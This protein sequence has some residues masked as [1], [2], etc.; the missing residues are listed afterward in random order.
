MRNFLRQPLH[1]VRITMTNLA[2]SSGVGDWQQLSV[3]LDSPTV[4]IVDSLKRVGVDM[5][6]SHYDTFEERCVFGMLS[7]I[8]QQNHGAQHEIINGSLGGHGHRR[9][10][11]ACRTNGEVVDAR[12][13]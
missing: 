1:Q 2:S 13:A 12:C 4:G 10:S 9:S 5:L 6:A 8:F 3:A 11:R 7:I